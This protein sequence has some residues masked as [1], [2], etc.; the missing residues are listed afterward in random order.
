MWH[1]SSGAEA[2]ADLPE[3]QMAQSYARNFELC[4]EGISNKDFYI[5]SLGEI[6][7][8]TLRAKTGKMDEPVTGELNITRD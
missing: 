7:Y 2:K 8:S 5:L 4:T 6:T 3:Y 1:R